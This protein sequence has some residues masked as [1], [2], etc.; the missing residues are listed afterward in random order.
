MSYHLTAYSPWEGFRV[1]FNGSQG[2]LEVEVVESSYVSG[3]HDDFNMPGLRDLAPL[4]ER[5]RPE[6]VLRPLWG[7][8]LV[9][10]VQEETGA[11]GHGG[12]DVR[13]LADLFS[14]E[15]PPDPLGRA[16]GHREGALSILTGIAANRSF[17]TGQPVQVAELVQL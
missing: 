12:G 6:I 4:P 13:L 3:A 11:G 1:M 9:V 5:E 7:K 14:P 8:P 2:R 15:R 16:A 10:P 17:V